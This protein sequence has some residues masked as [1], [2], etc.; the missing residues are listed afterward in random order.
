MRFP[1]FALMLLWSTLIQPARPLGLGGGWIVAQVGALDFAGGTVV[2]ISS[3]VSALVTALYLGKRVGYPES[4]MR[5]WLAVQR[6]RRLPSWAGWSGFNAGSAVS[7]GELAATAFVNTNTQLRRGSGW[8]AVE[9]L[10]WQAYHAGAPPAR[11]P[12]GGD[13]AARGRTPTAAI[14]IGGLGG[15]RLSR[16]QHEAA[17]RIRRRSRRRGVHG[18][19]HGGGAH[20]RSPPCW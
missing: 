14:V 2:H 18:W 15:R 17:P 19:A 11:S 8:L 1:S 7:S 10:R 5:R 12:A 6:G 3:G 9:W 20:G 16:G 13:D 4:A